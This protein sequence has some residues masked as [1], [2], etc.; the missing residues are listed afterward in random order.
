MTALRQRL[1]YHSVERA[2]ASP[3]AR[4]FGDKIPSPSPSTQSDISQ[5]LA[6]NSTWGRERPEIVLMRAK[7]CG[8]VGYSS[9]RQ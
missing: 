5:T 6:T 9:T 3:V 7:D 1:L 4:G 8:T 2:A